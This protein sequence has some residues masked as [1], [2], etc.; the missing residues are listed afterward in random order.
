M[1]AAA[2]SHTKELHLSL[3]EPTVESLYSQDRMCVHVTS[4]TSLA[5]MLL[6]K[7]QI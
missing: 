6:M 1:L 4:D 5:F 7:I 3:S 2:R